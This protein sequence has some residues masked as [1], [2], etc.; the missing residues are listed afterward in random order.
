MS[1]RPV[2][3]ALH[4]VSISR[5]VLVSTFTL[6]GS[7]YLSYNQRTHASSGATVIV[8]TAQ[9]SEYLYDRVSD[10]VCDQL[11]RMIVSLEIEPGALLVESQL[12]ER[13]G[14][15]RTPLREAIQRL[16]DENL[17]VALPRRAISVAEITVA[18]LQ[19]IYEARWHLEPA[20]GRLAAERI[21]GDGL[22]RL[23]ALLA[24]PQ[25]KAP[26]ATPFEVTEWDMAFHRSI[27]E[28]SGNRYL[29]AAFAQ[30]QGPA[31][32][33]L[34]FAYRRGPFI[35]PTIDEHRSIFDAL[36]ARDPD[37]AAQ[38]LDRHIRNAKDRILRTI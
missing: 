12:M 9:F 34:V 6:P 11:R 29:L 3:P 1:Q 38:H 5:Q 2:C 28:A 25:P 22:C 18:G 33:L 19:Q 7:I 30:L 27:A 16:H 32:R 24:G 14:C 31:Q 17:V 13:L 15:G 35:P 10:R 21:D 20:L 23:E 26:A 36:H 37:A 4:A 8:S